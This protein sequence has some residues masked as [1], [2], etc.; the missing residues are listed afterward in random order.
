MPEL[1]G[2]K[3]VTAAIAYDCPDSF[4]TFIL[5]FPQSLYFPSM[6]RHLICPDQLREHG[7]VVNDIPL[8]RIPPQQRTP[9]H[10]SIIDP[11]SKLHIPLHYDKPISYFH[12]RKPT[13]TEIQDNL[14]NI[15]VY[16]TS[17]LEWNPYDE[18]AAKD[19]T[20]L[21]EQLHREHNYF[22]GNDFSSQ[23][24]LGDRVMGALK[25]I[26]R[27]GNVTAEQL[28]R[29]WRCG[30][31]TAKKTIERTTQRAVQDFTDVRGMRR[32]KPTV[33]QLKY[34]RLRAE[35]YTDS[36]YGPCVSLD[37]NK[38]CQIY[39]SVHQ[40]CKAFPMKS[41]S[42]AHLTQDK[43]FRSVG[44][45]VAII[46]DYALELTQGKFLRNAQR[47]QVQILPVEPYMHNLNLAE[48]CIREVLR[49]YHRF[50]TLRGI[51]KVLWD[52]CFVYCCELR[53][54]MVL[55][56]HE[57]DGECGATIIY[58]ETADI[59]HLAEFSFYDWVWFI[60]PKESAYDRMLL[61]RWLGPSFD[62]GEAMT[63][64]IFTGTAEIV[65]RS[66]VLPLSVE[67]RRNEDIKHMKASFLDQVSRKLGERAKG[68][69]SDQNDVE[70]VRNKFNESVPYFEKYE[71]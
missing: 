50:M 55:G 16:M 5:I 66:S 67:E 10:H 70:F 41:K 45:P 6:E 44:F 69:E 19:E 2:V 25:M 58:G 26:N 49:L 34:K 56:H 4:I 71:T 7:I 22:V 12:C 29:Q 20:L 13:T 54:H 62:V 21:R 28:A 24:V 27:K 61:G 11:E 38:Y 1:P 64:A 48:T 14:N 63:F 35:L 39:A 40:W 68:I 51:P 31:E 32:L 8:I 3:I 65:H 18:V 57:Q 53:S 17:E 46:P 37:G 30:L 15:H 23:L 36:Y 59:S 9:F 42:D 47:A 52:R 43:L 33:Y 60:S